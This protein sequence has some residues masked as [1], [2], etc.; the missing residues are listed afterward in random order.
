M[1]TVGQVA[2]LIL[3][4]EP[5]KNP[6]RL[7]FYHFLKNFLNIEAQFVPTHL[8]AFYDRAM[9]IQH[10]QTNRA[11][12]AQVVRADLT[13][14]ANRHTFG[15]DTSALVHC[16]EVQWVH[17]EMP[18][19]FETLLSRE[20]QALEE[21]GEIV[22]H[23]PFENNEILRLRLNPAAG[24]VVET[25]SKTA[26]V[27]QGELRLVR[28]MTRLMYDGDYELSAQT[29]Q[30]LNI[31]LTRTAVFRVSD[32]KINGYVIQGYTFAKVENLIGPVQQHWELFQALK[33]YERHFINPVTDKDY[34]HL[35][36]QLEKAVNLMKSYHP[37]REMI[38]AELVRKGE[39][40]LRDLFPNDRLLFHLV[41][42]LQYH[43]GKQHKGTPD[44]WIK[45]RS[46][47]PTQDL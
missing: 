16:D 24:L 20:Q 45:S 8:D 26:F 3:T 29:D 4:L 35:V 6:A 25:K 27:D 39:A 15:F 30:I 31:S 18:A 19:D 36:E 14:L 1:L 42:T 37:D 47:S 21:K 7:A 13:S 40:A 11:D 43:L 46:A 41:S 12:L 28:P 17:I 10:W 44:S 23:I 34:G 33:K 22:R 32:S 5:Q 2:S 38:A 9:T